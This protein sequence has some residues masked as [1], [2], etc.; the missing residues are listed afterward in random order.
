MPAWPKP[1]QRGLPKRK[2]IGEQSK[3]QVDENRPGVYNRDERRCIVTG[4]MWA[5]FEPCIGALTIQHATGKGAGSSALFDS[6]EY[7]RT[8]CTG[9][10]VLQTS[11]ARFARYCRFMGWSLER[12]RRGVDPTRVPVRYPD[13]KDYFLDSA[14]QKHEISKSTAADIRNEMHG[15]ILDVDHLEQLLGIT[16]LPWQK[17]YAAAALTGG[18]VVMSSSRQNGRR[19]VRALITEAQNYPALYPPK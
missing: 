6:P 1:S 15:P 19:V 8:M 11:N 2:T 9:H 16:L 17:Q 13:G 14:F 18:R 7:L 5:T 12:N 10:N 3:A 4:S